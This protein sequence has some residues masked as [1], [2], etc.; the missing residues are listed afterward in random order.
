M[1]RLAVVVVYR[2]VSSTDVFIWGSFWSCV[3]VVCVLLACRYVIMFSPCLCFLYEGQ[4]LCL[5]VW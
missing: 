4:V 1:F 5:V 2:C 3:D